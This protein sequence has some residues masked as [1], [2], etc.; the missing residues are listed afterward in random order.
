MELYMQNREHGR[1][2][3]ELVEHVP[4]IWPTIEENGVTRTKKYEEL[5]A[6]EKIQ[7]NCDLKATNIILQGLPSDV[8][9]LINHHRVAKDLWER[10]QL[11]MQDLYTTNF[12]QLHAYLEQ[13]ELHANEVRIMRE[14]NQDPLALVAN[15][16]MTPSHFDTINLHTTIL[17]D[18]P[19]DAINKMISF[20]STVV[21]SRFLT[22]NNQLRNS[23]NQRQPSTIHDGRANISGTG[24]N[25][26]GQQR[27][28]KCFNCQEEGHMARQCP[29]QKMKRNA[30]WFRD[31]VLLVEAQGYGKILNEEELEFLEDPGVAEGPVTQTVITHNAA[32]QADNLDAYDSDCD[33]LYTA[34]AVLMAN[35]SSYGSNVLSE[36][37]NSSTQQDAMILFVFEQLSNQVNNCNKVNK[38]NL[39]ANESLSAKLERYKER[40]KK[41]QFVDFEKEINYLKQTLSKQSKENELLTKTFNVFKNQSKEKEAKNIDKEISLEKKVKELN[42]IV[43]KMGQSAQTAHML[44]KLQVFYDNN[45]KQALGFQNPFYLK[46]AQQIRPMLYD[47]SVIA[48]E[49][50]VI[51]IVDSEETLMLEEE[52]RSKMLLKQKLSDEQAFRL[53]T[54]HPNTDQYASSLVKIKAPRELPKIMPDALTEGEWGFEHTKAVFIKET[55]PFLKT[56][57]DII[58]VFDKDLLNKYKLIQE[59]IGYVRDT[60]PDIHKPSEK[61]VAVTPINKKKTVRFAEPVISSSTSQKQ[62]GSSQTK[63]K[64]TTNN[65]V[66]TS[67]GVS[68]STK[69]SRSKSTN[70]TKNDRI[71]QISSSTQKKNKVEDH[72]RIVKSCLNK[73]NCVVEPSGNA[74]VQ[75]SKLNTN[76]E[77]MC[78]KCN[79]SMF[80]ARHELCFLEFV[81]D[82]N[83]SSK[84]KSVKKAKK[85]EEWKPTGKVFTKIGYNW[86]PTG[87]TFT[88]V[89]NA[90]PLTRITATN[91]VPLREPIPLEVV[92]IVF[93]YLDFGCSKHMI[94]DRS[95][96]TNFVHKFLGT[97]KFSNDHIAKIIGYGDYQIGNITI[98]RVYYVEGLGHNLFFV[99]QFCD[100]DLEVAFKK[101]TCFVRNL[102]GDDL[103]SRSQ[104]TN[105]YTL[106]IGDMMTSSPICLL[107]KASKTKSWLWYRRLSYLN[108][109]AINHLA[110]NG[111]VRGLVP[112]PIPQQP[113]I[114]PSRDDW[115]RLFQPMFDEYFNHPTIVVSPVPVAAAPITVD[116]A[117]SP[118]STSIDQD[119]S[120]KVSHQ[121]KNKNILQ[122]FLKTSCSGIKQEEGIN[123][124]ESFSL[125]ARIEA[126]CIFIANAANKNMTIFQM[127]VKTAFLNGQLKEEVYVSQPEG[128]VD[129]DN[130]SH[131][132]K[133]KKAL[134][135]LKQAPR[136]HAYA[137]ADHV[138]FQDTRRST[139][140]SAQFL[141]DKLVSWSSKKQKSTA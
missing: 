9:S 6:T 82:M 73:P 131:V 140:G 3:L 13:H 107:S 84:S 15:H 88:L 56:L 117:D 60:C 46:K 66:S 44:T 113:C 116:L 11:L 120:L 69:S 4:L 114:P 63:T 59:L 71:L 51:S 118:V 74:H 70:N 33:D 64:Q 81:S 34:K 47:G 85:K 86:R 48:K 17:R 105:L 50:N 49:N 136:V 94:G 75:H 126:I 128:F 95:Q 98:S 110:Q 32:Y 40:E 53:H 61:L 26:S 132:Y 121:H 89:G 58:N 41:A 127:D 62:L 99:G 37:T 96:L 111:L 133:L 12:N 109:G 141:G 39:I 1:M 115:D 93:W 20:L 119:A 138:G 104:E 79:S 52:S 100:S 36:D 14:R 35:F 29:K 54:S 72:S 130:P 57:R 102:E 122:L 42:N 112:N 97:V 7:A 134:Y 2:I 65:S 101:H 123:F 30:T 83:A 76:S 25:N 137:D 19:I 24:G 43:C 10:V 77:L 38:D 8:Y 108:F 31:K 23:S 28:V 67:T 80:D 68:R 16:Q 90:C 5:S 106:S 103:L 55:I 27:F 21:T 18:D 135:S 22:T 78:V 91:K 129:Q 92:Q 45:L 87:R 125:V 139:S 124:E